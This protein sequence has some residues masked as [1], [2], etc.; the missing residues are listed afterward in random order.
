MG[1]IGNI[2]SGRFRK[3]NSVSLP[4]LNIVP[5]ISSA[6]IGQSAGGDIPPKYALISMYFSKPDDAL[7]QKYGPQKKGASLLPPMRSATR[8]FKKY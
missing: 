4:R 5:K 8:G 6:G 7:P 1:V 2:V 3:R